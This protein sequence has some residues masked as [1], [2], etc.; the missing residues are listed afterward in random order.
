MRFFVF[1]CLVWPFLLTAEDSPS[2]DALRFFFRMRILKMIDETGSVCDLEF[3]R[4]AK[5][6]IPHILNRSD[7]P[8]LSAQYERTEAGEEIFVVS[9]VHPEATQTVKVE[10]S[11]PF[12]NQSSL[13][14]FPS[15]IDSP[16]S[17]RLRIP[18]SE[19]GTV[20]VICNL[21]ERTFVSGAMIAKRS[22]IEAVPSVVVD[23]SDQKLMKLWNIFSLFSSA[24]RD[25]SD[26]QVRFSQNMAI[27]SV[28][29]P[30]LIDACRTKR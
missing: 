29:G 7:C 21:I 6:H 30:Q 19:T 16:I 1:A 17:M 9:S 26:R 4:D 13:V 10:F 23:K 5:S 28:E 14:V 12:E 27:D 22:E 25:L 20:R 8:A 24:Y 2:G 15:A 11:G 3:K 18:K